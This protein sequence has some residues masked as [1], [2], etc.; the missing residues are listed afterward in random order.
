MYTTPEPTQRKL[1]VH[2]KDENQILPQD[3]A[4]KKKIG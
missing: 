1:L 2:S 3:A 4:L